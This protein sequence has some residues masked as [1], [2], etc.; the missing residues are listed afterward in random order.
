MQTVPASQRRSSVAAS[1]I[2]KVRSSSTPAA[3]ALRR[4][5]P[6]ASAERSAHTMGGSGA[7]G[8][9]TAAS[10]SARVSSQEARVV[11]SRVGQRS[12]AKRRRRPGGTPRAA[13]ACS[14]ASVPPPA[15]GSTNGLSSAT[16]PS[17]STAAASVSLSGASVMATRQPRRCSG[18]PARSRNSAPCPP[19]TCSTIETSGFLG[20]T[21]GRAPSASRSEST[22]ASFTLSAA[23]PECVS[24]G[25]SFTL[26]STASVLV[27]VSHFVQSTARAPS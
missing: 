8:A 15:I 5:A 14:M 18:S 25:L 12:K 4:A 26:A 20:S 9:R 23:K 6:S 16:F 3:E 21:S 2:S 10:A 22:T 13:S 7:R 11:S 17:A 1:A 19:A 24:A 27:A